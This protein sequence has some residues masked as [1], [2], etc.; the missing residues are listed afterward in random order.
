MLDA[1]LGAIDVETVVVETVDVETVLAERIAYERARRG[2]SLVDFAERS[3][4]SRSML[5]KIERKEAS[6]TTMVLVRI[7]IAFGLTLAEL[8]TEST[9]ADTRLARAADQPIW[10]DP[11]TGY[12]RRQIYM[13]A[14]TPLELTEL[15]LPA[16]ASVAAPANYY[17]LV[18]EVIW[19][20]EGTLTINEGESRTKLGPGDRLEFGAPS[21][22]AFVNDSDK[23]CR[24]VVVILRLSKRVVA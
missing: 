2:W 18:R 20:L 15:E 9:P 5:S 16:G 13:S 19:V 12:R 4:V 6:P 21:D 14:T 23:P 11:G 7:S 8:L 17:Q 1:V 24:F 10:C 22:V 3:G